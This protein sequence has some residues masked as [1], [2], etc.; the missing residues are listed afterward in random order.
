MKRLCLSIL[1]LCLYAHVS[2]G[3]TNDN[4]WTQW[5]TVYQKG[6]KTVQVSFKLKDC[7]TAGGEA[8]T[9]FGYWRSYNEFASDKGWLSFSFDYEDCKGGTHS[10]TARISLSSIGIVTNSDW[11]KGYK[12][13]R[14]FYDVQVTGLEAPPSSSSQSSSSSINSSLMSP[15]TSTINTTSSSATARQ[16]QML[17]QINGVMA[18]Q[19][20]QSQQI[21]DVQ[22]SVAGVMAQIQNDNIKK[23][24]RQTIE[25]RDKAF[26]Q[27]QKDI[28]N[29]RVESLERCSVCTSNGLVT[30][31]VCEGAR[32]KSCASCQG[33]GKI[34]SFGN[35]TACTTC[36]GTG[37]TACRSCG[38][39][40]F[41]LC[42]RCH[43]NGHDVL[44]GSGPPPKEDN[45]PPPVPESFNIGYRGE[46]AKVVALGD[47]YWINKNLNVVRFA[48]GDEIQQSTNPREWRDAWQ[49]EQPRWAYIKWDSSTGPAYGKFYNWF[50]VIDRR[51]LCPAGWH[52]PDE[53]EWDKLVNF[54]G[55]K[56]ETKLMSKEGWKGRQGTDNYG[57]N[58]V[59]A[60]YM[61]GNSLGNDSM[62][63]RSEASWWSSTFGYTVNFGHSLKGPIT[64]SI[65]KDGKDQIYKSAQQAKDGYT[66]RCISD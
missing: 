13:V 52:V 32:F 45:G 26:L 12:I 50:A 18:R 57:F 27:L 29:G 25:K 4:N 6:G 10:S 63:Q 51:G 35:T 66:V 49:N 38:G 14:S 46:K 15:A 3:Q 34:Q 44:Y 28:K 30:C 11:F 36:Y 40:G 56:P 62:G 22:S 65:S 9:P 1:V 53:D 20:A 8:M 21:W 17:E 58:A 2:D 5:V 7:Y 60:G 59:A 42:D 37:Q 24:T 61:W 39:V 23:S 54:L 48:N 16:Q 55:S 41:E 43:G 64:Y 33:S 31:T 19:Q 47:Q